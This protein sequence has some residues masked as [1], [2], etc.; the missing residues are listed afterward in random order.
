MD[1]FIFV[2]AAISSSLLTQVCG[3]EL[4]MEEL[5]E[6]TGEMMEKLTL[7]TQTFSRL[8]LHPEEFVCLKVLLLLS[9]GKRELYP[10]GGGRCQYSDGTNVTGQTFDDLHIWED[11]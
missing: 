6:E 8:N 2:N 3:R 10:N 11:L 1:L 4:L 5:Q 9:R 7:L